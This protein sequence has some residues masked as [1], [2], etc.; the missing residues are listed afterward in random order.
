M[1]RVY[2]AEEI[3]QHRIYYIIQGVNSLWKLNIY[4]YVFWRVFLFV[5]V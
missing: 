1:A 3:R 4:H 2:Q 5:A